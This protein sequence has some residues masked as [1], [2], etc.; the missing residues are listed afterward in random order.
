MNTER[1]A[2]PS[3]KFHEILI[4]F[5]QKLRDIAR[6]GTAMADADAKYQTVNKQHWIISVSRIKLAE[7]TPVCNYTETRVRTIYSTTESILI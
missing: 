3:I 7:L 4:K 6:H 5:K 1:S 2:K